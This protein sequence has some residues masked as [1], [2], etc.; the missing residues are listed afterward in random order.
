MNG[1]MRGMRGMR[2]MREMRRN[3]FYISQYPIPNH[4]FLR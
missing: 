1:E 4:Q 3:N 2:G